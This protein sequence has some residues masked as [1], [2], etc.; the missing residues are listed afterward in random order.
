MQVC[1]RERKIQ[2]DGL[3]VLASVLFEKKIA[4]ESEW[5]SVTVLKTRG[6]VR[7]TSLDAAEVASNV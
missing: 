3:R 4:R 1:A 6:V 7:D 2:T 5:W